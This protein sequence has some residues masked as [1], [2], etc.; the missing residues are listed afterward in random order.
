M[1]AGCDLRKSAIGDSI[2]VNTVVARA[3]KTIASTPVGSLPK[4]N[5]PS[6]MTASTARQS[7]TA[8]SRISSSEWRKTLHPKNLSHAPARRAGDQCADD[9]WHGVETGTRMPPAVCAN[10]VGIEGDEG[11]VLFQSALHEERNSALGGVKVRVEIN[12]AG[13]RQVIHDE[14]G[15]TH[16]QARVLNEWQLALG[17]RA[18][19]G[20]VDDLVGNM[21]D[22]Q[23]SLELAAEWAQVRDRE[24]ARELE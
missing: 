21:R 9:R 11:I 7:R 13:F 22:A 1:H 24:H 3:A 18:G 17:P 6:P 8:D 2:G 10:E 14:R 12:P 4:K 5:G 15:V 16:A 20:R 19:I 23:P